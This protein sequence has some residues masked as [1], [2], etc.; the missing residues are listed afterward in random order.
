MRISNRFRAVVRVTRI[1][2]LVRGDRLDSHRRRA[3]GAPGNVVV[4]KRKTNATSDPTVRDQK[5]S[6][7]LERATPGDHASSLGTHSASAPT[8]ASP[9]AAQSSPDSF[10]WTVANY[11]DVAQCDVASTTTVPCVLILIGDSS[12]A[13]AAQTLRLSM[14]NYLFS[15]AEVV[16]DGLAAPPRLDSASMELSAELWR[17]ARVEDEH[18]Q[19]VLAACAG[20]KSEAARRLGITRKTLQKKVAIRRT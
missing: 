19:R 9:A 17:L 1:T 15:L 7:P 3:S 12:P 8:T 6:R 18:I 5:R 16:K 14:R 2:A 11:W 20:N 10:R 4:M 13:V